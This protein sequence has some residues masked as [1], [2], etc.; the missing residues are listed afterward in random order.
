M[1]ACL[2]VEEGMRTTWQSQET[3][4]HCSGPS[5]THGNSCVRSPTGAVL[6]FTPAV[7]SGTDARSATPYTESDLTFYKDELLA[8]DTCTASSLCSQNSAWNSHF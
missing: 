8:S 5:A 4:P 1:V 7:C 3:P 2:F 6:T